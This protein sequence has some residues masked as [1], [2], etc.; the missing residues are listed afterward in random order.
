MVIY[1]EKLNINFL[2]CIS[3]QSITNGKACNPGTKL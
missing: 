2:L 1:A 3:E